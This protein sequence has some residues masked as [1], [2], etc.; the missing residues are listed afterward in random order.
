MGVVHVV[1]KIARRFGVQPKKQVASQGVVRAHERRS[2]SRSKELEVDLHR[3]KSAISEAFDD[4]RFA[5]YL[6]LGG[7][8]GELR[9]DL[10]RE[11]GM[12]PAD[13]R[14]IGSS[15][16]GPFGHL[17][18]FDLIIKSMHLGLSGCRKMQ[19]LVDFDRVPNRSYFDLWSS[20]V[21][22]R[23]ITAR[24]WADIDLLEWP[25][26][27][28][29]DF[30][31]T[32]TGYRGSMNMW[33]E[34]DRMWEA[35]RR[36]PLISLPPEIQ[37]NGR[38]VL[39][40]F[41]LED[42]QWI[43]CFHV[44]E[45]DHRESYRG[46]NADVATYL[47]AMEEVVRRGGVAIRMGNPE[48]RSLPKRDG[49]IDY[50]HSVRRA[51]WMD[52]Y[53]WASCRFFVGTGSGPI[54]VPGTFGVPVLMTNTSAV[55]MFS[56]YS[57]GSMMITK[58]FVDTRHRCEVPLDEALRRGAG[59]NWSADFSRMGLE[60]QDNSPEEIRLAVIDMM[61][62]AKNFETG[63]QRILAEQRTSAGSA[64]TTPFAP[65]FADMMASK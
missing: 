52:V 61:Q 53:L 65:S 7:E 8:A 24:E 32:T 39:K 3:L 54:H 62:P 59:W 57:P 30:I 49:I 25:I 48:M 14:L 36:D 63:G 34:V 16:L 18:L 6:R 1:R 37:R 45:G 27:E 4:G 64:I 38:E 47:P 46:P 20:L 23:K 51:D 12:D 13:R 55:G 29:A 17:A 10:A 40:R 42:G 35:E 26:C 9:D 33:D 50:A 31:R 11:W 56:P 58:H 22:V 5:D 15:F 19:V 60:L 41:G 2:T 44:R 21:D 28:N 43:V